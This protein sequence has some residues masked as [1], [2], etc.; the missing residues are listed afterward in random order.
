VYNY[1]LLFTITPVQAFISQARKTHDLW[2]GSRILSE[3]IEV[4]RT[5][6][7]NDYRA[8][9]VFPI[10]NT[11][12][13]DDESSNPNR[14]V[15]RVSTVNP[16]DIG[17]EL[18]RAV[19]IKFQE[20]AGKICEDV[21]GKK[22]SNIMGFKEQ[23][24]SF[25]QVYWVMMSI[26]E[27]NESYTKTYS[28]LEMR[29]GG[30]KNLRG[31]SQLGEEGYRKCSLCGERNALFYAPRLIDGTEKAP[32]FMAPHAIA[33]NHNRISAGEGLCAVC[34]V[35]RFWSASNEEFPSTATVA[36]MPLLD[37]LS[38]DDEGAELFSAYKNALNSCCGT[39]YQY[40]MYNDQLLYDDNLTPDYFKKNGLQIGV[41]K[42]ELGHE[43]IKP[44]IM[45]AYSKLQSYIRE[46]Q[47]EQSMARNND[48]EGSGSGN[49]SKSSY[50]ALIAFDG[51]SMG[52]WLSG[53]K[54]ND[55]MGL[56]DFH[57]ELSLKLNEFAGSVKEFF[58][59]PARKRNPDSSEKDNKTNANY[60]GRVVYAG[61][62]DFLGFVTLDDSLKSLDKLRIEFAEKVNQALHRKAFIQENNN[63][64]FSAGMVIAHYKTP[65]SEALKWVHRMEKAAKEVEGKNSLGIALL[66]HSGEIEKCVH[67][68]WEES[69]KIAGKTV[70]YGFLDIKEA[71]QKG[72]FSGRFIK[73]LNAELYL[74]AGKRA[75]YLGMDNAY[76]IM[77]VEIGRLLERAC[78]LKRGEG[79]T[80]EDY[81]KRKKE[82]I[83]Q[84]QEVVFRLYQNSSDSLENFISALN[85]VHFLTREVAGGVD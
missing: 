27:G 53:T 40:N 12:N 33:L 37:T 23:I 15:A 59:E 6:V 75:D 36:L 35:K 31:F 67:K 13:N 81:K 30:V 68:W 29:L 77:R 5:K 65:L 47:K 70:I 16:R 48:K 20:L 80:G 64:S 26:G 9:I 10:N 44:A 22:P 46:R 51:D 3:L 2:A 56:E 1:L 25:W 4:A 39:R 79:E 49:W 43:T 55:N 28:K 54:L 19:Q 21:C 41:L 24:K 69:K 58:I 11:D 57:Q 60:R 17:I 34:L 73:N 63:L 82:A 76:E 18:E 66:K 62:E 72:D 71:I 84:L 50:Y 42:D 52:E 74:L 7:V 78:N 45:G 83:G 38:K 85:I 8:E 14:F 61:G 32:R